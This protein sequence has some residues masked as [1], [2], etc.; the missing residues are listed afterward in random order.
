MDVV[1]AL[2]SPDMNSMCLYALG[3]MFPLLGAIGVQQQ[4]RLLMSVYAGY[5]MAAL[6]I[7]TLTASIGSVFLM[8]GDICALLQEHFSWDEAVLGSCDMNIGAFRVAFLVTTLGIVAV[9]AY[10]LR[11]MS[12]WYKYVKRTEWMMSGDMVEDR[13]IFPGNMA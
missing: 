4:N 3:S 1:L 13:D 6:F 7:L 12:L 10:V 2:K 8:R 11:Q 5:V 9:E